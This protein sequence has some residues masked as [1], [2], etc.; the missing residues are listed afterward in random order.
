MKNQ[1]LKLN[2]GSIEKNE[3]FG[4]WIEFFQTNCVNSKVK[5]KTIKSLMVNLWLNCI[6]LKS[7]IKLKKTHK[8]KVAFEI[9]TGIQLHKIKSL[10]LIGGAIRTIINWEVKSHFHLLLN[11][12]QMWAHYSITWIVQ[13]HYC[14]WGGNSSLIAMSSRRVAT[15]TYK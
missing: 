14:R 15:F 2:S 12:L 3:I 7:R 10:K 9:L 4:D 11:S 13:A 1:V 5:L 6:N 8:A